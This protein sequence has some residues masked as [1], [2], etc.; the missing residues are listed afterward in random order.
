MEDQVICKR[1]GTADNYHIEIKANN[2]CAY[3][4]GCGGFIKNIPHVEPRMY[5][6]R[7]NGMKIED[8]DDTPY[9][10]WVLAKTD[11]SGH[12]REAIELKISV[13]KTPS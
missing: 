8:I 1:C 13:T 5:F 11:V 12:I 4:N 6:G 2:H 10:K 7:Y 3:C 9:L